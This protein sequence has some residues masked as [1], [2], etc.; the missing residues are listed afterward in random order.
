MRALELVSTWPVPH[1][2]A[3]VVRADGRVVGTAG[4]VA[5]RFRLASLTKPI[6]AWAMLVAGARV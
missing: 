3:A 2:A 5:H 1:V 4:D 6:A